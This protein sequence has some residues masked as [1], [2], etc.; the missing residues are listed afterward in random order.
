MFRL[1]DV[2]QRGEKFW[3]KEMNCIDLKLTGRALV[4]NT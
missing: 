2:I 3:K 1:A 4:T